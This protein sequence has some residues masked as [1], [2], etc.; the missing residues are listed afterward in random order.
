M[1]PQT[2]TVSVGELDII[3]V[4]G[5]TLTLNLFALTVFLLLLPG[6]RHESESP[7]FI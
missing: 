4:L 2:E 6:H 1:Q 7:R 3:L 5:S